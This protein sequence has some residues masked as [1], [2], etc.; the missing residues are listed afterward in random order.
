MKKA[1]RSGHGRH[2]FDKRPSR[3]ESLDCCVADTA[4]SKPSQSV[5]PN[6][7]TPVYF[8]RGKVCQE[9][10]K[11]IMMTFARHDCPGAY[12]ITQAVWDNKCPEFVPCVD[13]W[14]ANCEWACNAILEHYSNKLLDYITMDSRSKEIL[15][16]DQFLLLPETIRSLMNNEVIVRNVTTE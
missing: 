15:G 14:K 11:A 16:Q 7:P 12:K 8:A 9:A 4:W 3:G 2:S 5:H 6:G 13:A 10:L 1:K